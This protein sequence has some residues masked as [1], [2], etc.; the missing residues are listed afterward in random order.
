MINVRSIRQEHI[1]KGAP[2]LVEVVSLECDLLPKG[3]VRGGLPRSVAEGL[4][5]F[6]AVD[7]AQ[8][9]T[10]RVGV[11]QDL[12]RVAIED[13]DDGAGKVCRI[14]G[15]GSV[16]SFTERPTMDNLSHH[17][18]KRLVVRKPPS[19]P[20]RLQ[21]DEWSKIRAYRRPP[22]LSSVSASSGTRS[23]K[24]SDYPRLALR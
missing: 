23:D 18:F 2:V 21:K 11:V 17:L 5:L 13:G 16:A 7:A 1:S 8:P 22:S 24:S 12:D 19:P 9:D 20:Y 10:L 14:Y 6:G 3:E 4:A 15:T